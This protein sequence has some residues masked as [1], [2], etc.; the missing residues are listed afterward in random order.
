MHGGD[1]H[2]IC[3]ISVGCLALGFVYAAIATCC[4]IVPACTPPYHYSNITITNA[5]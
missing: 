2:T 3:M 4:R 1:S 5:I